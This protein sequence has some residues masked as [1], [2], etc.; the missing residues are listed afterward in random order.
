M[1]KT[2]IA[3][4]WFRPKNTTFIKNVLFLRKA[5]QWYVYYFLFACHVAILGTWLLSC[6]DAFSAFSFWMWDMCMMHHC[7]IPSKI[8]PQSFAVNVWWL[9]RPAT[10]GTTLCH[11]HWTVTGKCM[12][13]K[14][15]CVTEERNMQNVLPI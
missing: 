15:F 14:T 4:C 6:R 3:V 11:I 5:H 10:C 12:Q 7:L 9:W 2:T 1:T 13:G 8:S